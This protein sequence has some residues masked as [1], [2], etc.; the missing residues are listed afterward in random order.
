MVYLTVYICV[1][2][3]L[4]TTVTRGVHK[5]FN[6]INRDQETINIAC[7][8]LTLLHQMCI[9]C[10]LFNYCFHVNNLQIMLRK[11]PL[12]NNYSY[13]VRWSKHVLCILCILCVLCY[14]YSL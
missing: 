6:C 9:L 5:K 1:T 10:Y 3:L 7:R 2:R 14:V 11:L 4:R 13:D 8:T 12:F